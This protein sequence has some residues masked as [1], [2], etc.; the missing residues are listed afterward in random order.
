MKHIRP[1]ARLTGRL[2]CGVL[3][4]KRGHEVLTGESLL[5][6]G[7]VAVSGPGS[8]WWILAGLGWLGRLTHLRDLELDRPLLNG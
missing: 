2:L 7:H 4:L 3:H 6:G 8:K 5:V 1:P